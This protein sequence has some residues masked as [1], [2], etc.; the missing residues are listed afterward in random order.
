M[1]QVYPPSA[2]GSK[3]AVNFMP[4][5]IGHSI[6]EVK[7]AMP[8]QNTAYG[9]VSARFRDEGPVGRGKSSLYPRST[10]HSQLKKS[11][12]FSRNLSRPLPLQGSEGR[13]LSP[14]A[15]GKLPA[16]ETM[17]QHQRLTRL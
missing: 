5:R 3:T 12:N 7:R 6:G 16:A 11:P 17:I 1:K 15:N 10:L 13:H 14:P 2:A 8:G 9:S 4:R